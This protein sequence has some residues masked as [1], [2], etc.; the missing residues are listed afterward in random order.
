[1]IDLASILSQICCGKSEMKLF[2]CYQFTDAYKRQGIQ[3]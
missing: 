2:M 3:M 1:M